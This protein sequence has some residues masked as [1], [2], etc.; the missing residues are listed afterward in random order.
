MDEA[1]AV[2]GDRGR[3]LVVEVAGDPEF[4]DVVVR[5]R[6]AAD[7]I[8][9]GADSGTWIGPLIDTMSDLVISDTWPTV[10][11]HADSRH[12]VS[13]RSGPAPGSAR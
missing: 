5:E 10:P 12:R 6:V 1:R 9:A 11:T 3:D 2:G 8:A 4:R 7:A 13:A